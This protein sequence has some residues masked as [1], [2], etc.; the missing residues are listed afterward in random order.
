MVWLWIEGFKM[1]RVCLCLDRL[2]AVEERVATA[3]E[4]LVALSVEMAA[5]SAR[6]VAS[7]EN[8]ENK[9]ERA[10]RLLMQKGVGNVTAVARAVGVTRKTLYNW[11][12]TR[13]IMDRLR[14]VEAW[15]MRN[16][17]AARPEEL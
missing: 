16:P 10:I 14:A 15:E 8:R 1:E 7:P 2:T 11:P 3:L 9:K 5:D 4:R 13:A 6:A 12:E 17:R